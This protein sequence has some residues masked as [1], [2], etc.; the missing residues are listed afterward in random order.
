M[1]FL[2]KANPQT[3]YPIIDNIFVSY[4]FV[5]YYVSSF[6]QKEEIRNVVKGLIILEVQTLKNQ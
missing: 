2:L 1:S 4:N 5:Q 6:L 3:M